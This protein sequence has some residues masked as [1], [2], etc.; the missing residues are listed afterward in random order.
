VKLPFTSAFQRNQL[1]PELLSL[2]DKL[3]E[4]V[5]NPFYGIITVG[6][7]AGQTIPRGQLLRPYPQY[8]S[9]AEA[10]PPAGGSSYNALVLSANRRFSNGLQFLVSFTAS[11][12][13]TN[14]EGNEGWTNGTAQNVRNWYDISLEKSLMINDIPKSLVVSYI[15][16]LPVGNGKKL[17]PDNKILEAVVGGWQIA[18]VST[19]KSGFPLSISAATNNTNSL[20]GNQ[21]PNLTGDPR[22]SNPTIDRWFN[23]DAF[24]QPPPFTFGNVPRTA[25]YLRSQGINNFDTTLQK[26][27]KLWGEQSRLQLRAEFYNLFNRTGFYAPNTTFGN[28]TFGIISGALPA[29]SIQLGM[30]LYW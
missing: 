25:S 11:K 30:K 15:Y 13:L 12:Y 19:F 6:S 29:R 28:P 21:R 4:P 1:R 23:T 16:E 22:L 27:W 17:A 9:V 5:A 10:Q 20:G 3:L 2:G 24:S 7:L 14:T 26:Y 18:G 8:T